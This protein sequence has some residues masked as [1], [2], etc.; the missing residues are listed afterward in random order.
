MVSYARHTV[1][2]ASK[3]LLGS[4]S[5]SVAGS[6]NGDVLAVLMGRFGRVNVKFKPTGKA[7]STAPPDGCKG[8]PAVLLRGSF[9][10]QMTFTGEDQYF[11][12][13]RTHAPG[14]VREA[15]WDCSVLR[16]RDEEPRGLRK[17]VSALAARSADGSRFFAVL[18]NVLERRLPVFLVGVSAR[19]GAVS[20]ERRA[21]AIGP[22]SGLDEAQRSV[23]V[24]P[25]T[26]FYGTATFDP[27]GPESHRWA[28]TLGVS[29]PGRIAFR[30]R[31]RDSESVQRGQG[32]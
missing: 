26:P 28:G 7:S 20:V 32:H 5:Y 24:Q 27:T 1:L 9:F 16:Q 11:S 8:K 17:G 3:G 29:L 6:M 25:S 21:I 22:S 23:T 13:K 2:T 10:G 12:I 18:G 14:V 19:R 31:D 4:T 15:R 30:S